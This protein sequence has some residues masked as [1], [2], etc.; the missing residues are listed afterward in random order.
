MKVCPYSQA[1]ADEIVIQI[2]LWKKSQE[3]KV[4]ELLNTHSIAFPE[5]KVCGTFAQ[6]QRSNA[7]EVV[8]M[9]S[10][11]GDTPLDSANTYEL[12]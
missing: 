4:L 6:Q 3:K 9:D 12:Q 5:M 7:N 11:R 2:M 10:F 8:R 1:F